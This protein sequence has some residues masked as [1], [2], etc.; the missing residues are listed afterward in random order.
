MAKILLIE[1]DP[2]QIIIYK[3]RFKIAK[4]ELLVANNGKD[5]LKMAEE[6]KPDVILIDIVMEGIGGMEVLEKLKQNSKTKDIPAL[7]LTNLYKKSLAQKA[8]DLGALDYIVKSK[9]SLSDTL[10]R[11][12]GHLKK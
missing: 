2:D 7:I 8:M 5:G 9:V 3:N 10:K 11:V 12:E 1:D 6:E 4:H